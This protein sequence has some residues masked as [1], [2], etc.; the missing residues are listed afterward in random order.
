MEEG[1][2]NIMSSAFGIALSALSA[3]DRKL[4]VNANNIANVNTDH[5]KKSR[6]HM[7][8]AAQG[9]VQVTIE[10]IHTPGIM[11][12]KNEGTGEELESSNVNL[13][14]EFVDQIITRYAFESNIIT[15]KTADKMQ[16]TLLDIMS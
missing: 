9:G 8:E 4:D 7:Q 12:G 5:F 15:V 3:F 10:Q 13:A 11:L 16:Q 6:V 1:G 2:G 14:E